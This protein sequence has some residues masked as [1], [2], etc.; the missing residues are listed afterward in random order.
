MVGGELPWSMYIYIYLY[1]EDRCEESTSTFFNKKQNL[2]QT[3]C[4]SQEVSHEDW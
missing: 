2:R 1:N 3:L 4:S